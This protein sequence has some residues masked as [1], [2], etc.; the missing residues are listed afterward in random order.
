MAK[1]KNSF[2]LY[3]NYIDV[4]N[5]LSNEQAGIL[6]KHILEYVNDKNPKAPIDPVV[7]IV[8]VGI[9]KQLKADLKKWEEEREKRSQAGKKGMESRYNKDKQSVTNDNNV[10]ECYN[11]A[12]TVKECITPITDNVNVNVNV[13][14]NVNDIDNVENNIFNNSTIKEVENNK[15]EKENACTPEFIFLLLEEIKDKLPEMEDITY[16]SLKNFLTTLTKNYTESNIRI[17]TQHALLSTLKKY[18]ELEN[19]FAYLRVTIANNC[20]QFKEGSYHY[21]N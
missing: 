11:N 5:A 13:N 12:S 18:D 1:D 8:W 16:L 19:T 6:F 2:V 17:S 9:Q 7:N 3:A 21:D 20:E 10:K 4:I 15:E 14:D